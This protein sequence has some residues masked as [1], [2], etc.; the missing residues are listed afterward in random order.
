MYEVLCACII[1][2]VDC[3][4]STNV[5]QFSYDRPPNS[6]RRGPKYFI[7]SKDYP[8]KEYYCT[9]TFLLMLEIKSL[10]HASSFIYAFRECVRK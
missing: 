6:F 1:I 9:S 3:C 2:N 7:E 4:F 8:E 5:A 10:Y